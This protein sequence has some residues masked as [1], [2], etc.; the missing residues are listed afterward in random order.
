MKKYLILLAKL[1]VF[2]IA[3]GCFMMVL[4]LPLASTGI[5][6]VNNPGR[7]AILLIEAVQLASVLL[8]AWLIIRFWDKVPF[9]ANMGFGIQ[10]RGKDMLY[11]FAMAA[12]IY[13][14][15]YIVSLIAGV[16]MLS[17]PA[18]SDRFIFPGKWAVQGIWI[19][20]TDADLNRTVPHSEPS[21]KTAERAR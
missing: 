9:V 8:A 2:A 21:W 19:S 16:C 3:M 20:E 1:I 7:W 13:A 18:R 11:G 6:D 10:G 14:I 12:T 5:V 15:G 4:M 17:Q